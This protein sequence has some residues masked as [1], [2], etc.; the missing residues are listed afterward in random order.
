MALSRS[1]ALVP[2]LR[3]LCKKSPLRCSSH[4]PAYAHVGDSIA[5]L[6]LVHRSKLLGFMATGGSPMCRGS[7]AIRC[8]ERAG[9][10]PVASTTNHGL[11]LAQTTTGTPGEPSLRAS[12]PTTTAAECRCSTGH[13]GLFNA[14]GSRSGELC[15]G[16]GT[17]CHALAPTLSVSALPSAYQPTSVQRL[18]AA[19]G[20]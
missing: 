15:Q 14:Q 8:I 16:E 5:H 4:A 3:R 2:R 6:A 18:P 10:G 7:E 13:A 11:G 9:T 12:Q 20:V 19:L 17:G 1:S